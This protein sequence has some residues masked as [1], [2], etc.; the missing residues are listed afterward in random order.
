[1]QVVA[2]V[3]PGLPAERVAALRGLC[4]GAHLALAVVFGSR[5]RGD[6]VATSD[7]DLLVLPDPSEP[8]DLLGFDDAAQQVAGSLR[9]DLTVLHSGINSALAWE[10]LRDAAVLWEGTPGTYA[11]EVAAWGARFRADA[12]LR[13]AQAAQLA[14][15]FGCP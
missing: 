4:E 14:R 15:A 13:R 2:P 11:R 9:V 7:L 3:V 8:L 10:A 6:A 1:M 12:P 5:A